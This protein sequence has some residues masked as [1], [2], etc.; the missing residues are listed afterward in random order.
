VLL[1]VQIIRIRH[2]LPSIA[3]LGDNAAGMTDP[4]VESIKRRIVADSQIASF[5]APTADTLTRVF[6][7]SCHIVPKVNLNIHSDVSPSITYPS[8]AIVH[9]RASV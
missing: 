2:P 5:H 1:T 9:V 8:G 3:N 6:P 4:V 7:P